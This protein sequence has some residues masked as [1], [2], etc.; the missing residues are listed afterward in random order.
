M[1]AKRVIPECGIGTV[2]R[3]SAYRWLTAEVIFQMLFL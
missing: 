1:P 3:G 2:Q